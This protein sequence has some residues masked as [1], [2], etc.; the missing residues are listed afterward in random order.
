MKVEEILKK[1]RIGRDRRNRKKE[2]EEGKRGRK[3]WKIGKE[4]GKKKK[5][6]KRGRGGVEEDRSYKE[7]K[8]NNSKKRN[9]MIS[10]MTC[11]K[12]RWSKLKKR[13]EDG[14]RKKRG[15]R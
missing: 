1:N 4:M 7:A 10:D 13:G 14:K 2:R 15:R 3:E 12:N 9:E 8:V 11:N 6:K 5:R